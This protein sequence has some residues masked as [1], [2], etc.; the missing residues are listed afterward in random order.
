MAHIR[1]VWGGLYRGKED[2]SLDWLALAWLVVRFKEKRPVY[3]LY[4]CQCAEVVK[5]L[6]GPWLRRVKSAVI[7]DSRRVPLSDL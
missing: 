1:D 6:K 2:R 3:G 4:I 5:H 7:K